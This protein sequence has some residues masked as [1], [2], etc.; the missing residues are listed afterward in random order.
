MNATLNSINL[1]S[2]EKIPLGQ[3][4][5]F[6][7]G[8]EEIAIFR[9]RDGR[10]F[11]VQNRCPHR[12]GPLAEGVIGGGKVICPLHSHKFN[13]ETGHGSEPDECVKTFSVG[14]VAGEIHLSLRQEE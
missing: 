12:Q 13:L 4:R 8:S 2:I 3:G 9:Q 14:E 10:F 5:C 6:I 11:A 7:V 1:G